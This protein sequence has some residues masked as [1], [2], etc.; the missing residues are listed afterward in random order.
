MH[1]DHESSYLHSTTKPRVKLV[2]ERTNLKSQQSFLIF[3]TM[4]ASPD[5]LICLRALK[6]SISLS[7]T[8]ATLLQ[9]SCFAQAEV[10]LKDAL[11]LI[12]SAFPEN[13]VS[14]QGTG[15]LIR[16]ALKRASGYLGLTTH[17]PNGIGMKTKQ[18]LTIPDEDNLQG[19]LEALDQEYLCAI[20]IDETRNYDNVQSIDIEAAVVLYNYGVAC[21][22]L[23]LLGK[24]ALGQDAFNFLRMSYGV[25]S[26]RAVWRNEDLSRQLVVSTLAAHNLVRLTV[27]QNMHKQSSC[28]CNELHNLR[29]AVAR[30]CRLTSYSL[31]PFAPAA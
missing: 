19:V 13:S 23:Q 3:F 5:A 24:S 27:E 8:G 31:P 21:R 28:Y 6:A 7:N 1:G 11:L 22:S 4:E 9:R 14:S 20:R 29:R 17:E 12:R 18:V 15:E 10:V 2:I 25:V 26:R 16:A 30:L